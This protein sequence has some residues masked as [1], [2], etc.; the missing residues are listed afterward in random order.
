MPTQMKAEAPPFVPAQQQPALPMAPTA[1]PEETKSSR[2]SWC[3]EPVD[4]E[5]V[6]S[7]ERV[8]SETEAPA[9]HSASALRRMRR[10]RASER[11][12]SEV[13]PRGSEEALDMEKLR[14]RLDTDP[15]G[16]ARQLRGQVYAL[17]CDA[18]HC[19]LL[20][21]VLERCS[22]REGQ[23]LAEE[24]EGYVW[25]LST[26]PHG[27]Y[28]VQKMVSHLSAAA[29]DLVAQELRHFAVR[30]AKNR[31]ACRILC[32]LMEF[33]GAGGPT[34][35]LIEEL[36]GEVGAL[37]FHS[38]AHHVI[39]SVLEHGEADQKHRIAQ[40]LLADAFRF[41]THKHSSY[42]IEK[43]LDYCSEEDRGQLIN[44]L[45]KPQMLLELAQ[46]QY[47]S[48]VARALLRDDHVDAEKAM[49]LFRQHQGEL[50]QSKHGF[51]LLS[52]LGLIQA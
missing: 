17:A 4:A 45:G 34:W 41:A 23:P 9:K 50:E 5:E 25:E 31:Q 51:R 20:Q 16:V 43:V 38:Y 42:L 33:R 18:K 7:I 3:D 32:R 29:S 21:E 35:Y 1:A 19:R 49:R 26:H 48:Y 27:N 30:A 40:A 24:L 14:K 6:P 15:N 39:Q 2:T 44:S 52:D 28:V 11:L 22:S 12:R 47:G 10:K 36:L 37:C 13:E 8:T 46:T